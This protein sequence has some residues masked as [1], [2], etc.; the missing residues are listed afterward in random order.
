MPRSRMRQH[1]VCLSR[2]LV[3]EDPA[4]RTQ[5]GGLIEA[6]YNRRMTNDP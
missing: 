5:T 1:L 2:C 6:T 4:P 3:V